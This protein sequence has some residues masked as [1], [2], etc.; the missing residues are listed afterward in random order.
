M[1]KLQFLVLIM[2]I[3]QY[4][5][6]ATVIDLFVVFAFFVFMLVLLCFCVVTGF[7]GE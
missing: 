1:D 5:V 4:I 6:S 2:F 7:F 3:L